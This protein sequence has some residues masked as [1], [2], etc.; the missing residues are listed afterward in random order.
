MQALRAIVYVSTATQAMRLPQLEALLVEA[1]RLNLQNDVTGMLLYSDGCFMQCFEGLEDAVHDTYARIR[2]SRQ[3]TRIV[4]LLNEQVDARSF[5]DWQMGFAQP[6]PADW[7]TLSHARWRS[8]AS[9]AL[10]SVA[11]SPGL[12]LLRGVAARSGR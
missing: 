1:R 2:A 11:N 8:M 7:M 10:C 9:E 6:E 5:A 3:H 4:E 12:D